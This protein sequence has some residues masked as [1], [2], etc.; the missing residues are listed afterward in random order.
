MDLTYA[1]LV[2]IVAWLLVLTFFLY[3]AV[4]HYKNLVA[5][6]SSKS[7]DQI[8][9][10]LTKEMDRGSK[11]IEQIKSAVNILDKDRKH[12]L[13]KFGYVKFDPFG[14]SVGGE[15]SFVIAILDDTDSGYVET[16]MYTRGKMRVYVKPVKN[17]KAG[18]FKLSQE[19]KEAIEKA[20]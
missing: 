7:I 20:K 4:R 3:R 13:Q 15:Q 17:G 16:F 11:D 8:L 9:D 2:I 12:Y 19:E 14:D 5:H 6:T 1:V 10:S 18:E